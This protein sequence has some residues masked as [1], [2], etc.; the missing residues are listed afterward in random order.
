MLNDYSWDMTGYIPK[1]GFQCLEKGLTRL[2]AERTFQLEPEPPQADNINE[3]IVMANREKELRYLCFFLHHYEKMLNGRLYRFFHREGGLCYDPE[4]FLNYKLGCLS[5]ILDCLPGYN[6][7][8]G[9]DFLTYAYYDIGNAIL[10]CRRY[11]EAGSFK[12]LEEYKTVRGIAW[13]YSKSDDSRKKT[14]AAFMKRKRSI[15]AR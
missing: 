13:L 14:L 4:R 8:K 1:Y 7:D 11:E 15:I 9:A 2:E 3:Y 12:N 10:D 5:A 6:P